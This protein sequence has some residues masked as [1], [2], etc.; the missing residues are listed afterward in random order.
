MVRCG[1]GGCVSGGS[2]VCRGSVLGRGGM[3]CASCVL[4]TSGFGRVI[5]ATTAA[6]RAIIEAPI[7]IN[8]TKAYIRKV[9]K[10]AHRQIYVK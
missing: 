5:I 9:R 4:S 8:D 2:V 1:G 7:N 10:E 6:T 3:M